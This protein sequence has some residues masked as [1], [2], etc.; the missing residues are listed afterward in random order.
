M[1]ISGTGTFDVPTGGNNLTVSGIVSGAAVAK[2]GS[3]TLTFNGVT[4]TP[5]SWSATSIVAPVP[6]GVTTGNVVV[7]VNGIASA[8][9]AFTTVPVNPYT[10]YTQQWNATL[11]RE[12]GKG[13]AVEMGYVGSHY[14]GGLGIWDPYIARV[15]STSS[16]LTVRD[17][18]GNSYTITNNTVNNEELRHQII[19]LSRKRGARYSGNIG[20]AIYNSFQATVSRDSQCARARARL[21][22]GAPWV[23]TD[24]TWLAAS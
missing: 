13:W 1:A 12:I 17:I 3:G 2:T 22:R 4:A 14:I 19:G 24:S 8:G 5:T 7:T 16:P 23:L 11:Q 9:V 15:V 10:P 6:A 18:N 21:P 20:F